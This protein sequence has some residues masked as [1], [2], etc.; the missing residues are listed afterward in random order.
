VSY[1]ILDLSQA[2]P[3]GHE[4]LLARVRFGLDEPTTH[5]QKDLEERSK[6]HDTLYAEAGRN[7]VR[8]SRNLTPGLYRAIQS[9]A[10]R[11]LLR[12]APEAFITQ[13][14]DVNAS[15]V[16]DGKRSFLLFDSALVELLEPDELAAIVGHEIAHASYGHHSDSGTHEIEQVLDTARGRAQELSADRVGLI[17][18]GDPEHAVR[19]EI[20]VA[21]GLS[22]RHLAANLDAFMDELMR[23]EAA[24]QEADDQDW[25]DLAT[26]PDFRF[27]FWAQKRFMESDTFRSLKGLSGGEPF[28]RVEAEIEERF[29]STGTGLAFRKTADHVHES[30][31]WLGVLA[32]AEDG[33]VTE[34][35]HL[36]LVEVVG[37]IWADD[38]Y[39]YARRHGLKAVERRAKETLA[40]LRFAS[41]RSRR[42]META[43]RE[44]ADKAGAKHR[45]DPLMQL[46]AEALKG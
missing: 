15:C 32:V 36:A 11:L 33:T 39:S 24:Q 19:A 17:A 13:S 18:A 28:D 45:V 40:P 42:R 21:S 37:R 34:R 5:L 7:A 8:I 14:S 3:L 10:E 4:E 12:E 27:R 1:P 25:A 9:A 16:S 23:D 29:L 35:E 6:A 2:A 30:L 26:H 31:A 38:A 20:K 44:L 46:L 41:L 43:L 22:S